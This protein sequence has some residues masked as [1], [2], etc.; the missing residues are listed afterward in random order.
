[1]EA[2]LVTTP[3][4]TFFGD[5]L[6][7]SF[8]DLDIPHRGAL[9]YLA[10]LLA[11]FAAVGALYPDDGAGRRLETFGDRLAAIQRTWQLDGPAFDPGRE[12]QIRQ[13]IAESALFLSGFFWERVRAESATRHY[14]RQGRRAYRF[15]AGYHRAHGRPAAEVYAALAA[16]FETYAAVLAYMRDVHLGADFAPWPHTAFT[17]IIATRGRGA[18]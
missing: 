14:H 5:L 8:A 17:R 12:V 4:T 15:L 9:E 10:D 11:R 2:R 18:G 3:L 1:M 6:A 7:R 16:R 13:G